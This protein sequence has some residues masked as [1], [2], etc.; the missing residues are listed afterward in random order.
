MRKDD[1]QCQ[2]KP[3]VWERHPIL[4]TERQAGH[5]TN[6]LIF[7]GAKPERGENNTGEMS[8]ATQN[9]MKIFSRRSRG[10]STSKDMEEPPG[11]KPSQEGELQH[12]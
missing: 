6:C 7:R 11:K 1:S 3:D 5:M 4:T 8:D 12:K 9:G 10:H 2:L